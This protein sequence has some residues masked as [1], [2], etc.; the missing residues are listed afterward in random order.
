MFEVGRV[1]VKIAGRDSGRKCVVVDVVDDT[2]VLIDGDVRRKKVNAK[3]LDPTGEVLDIKK[4]ATHEEV[5]AEFKKLGLP[6]WNKKAKKVLSKPTKQRKVKEK[7]EEKPKKAA[8]TEKKEEP[9]V[10]VPKAE[11]KVEEKVPLEEK[12]EDVKKS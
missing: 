3:H 4:G 8:K 5:E 9:K 6:V 2:F 10:E 1:A 11:P 7:E 12:K